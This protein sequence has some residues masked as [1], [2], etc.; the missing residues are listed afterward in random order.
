M[1]SSGLRSA[2][3]ATALIAKASPGRRRVS[4]DSA[5]A[6]SS[7]AAMAAR[8]MRKLAATVAHSHPDRQRTLSEGVEW[9]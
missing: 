8:T 3:I 6:T 7:A 4:S 2:T 1:T 5:E 9:S